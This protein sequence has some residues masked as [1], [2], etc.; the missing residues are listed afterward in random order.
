MENNRDLSNPIPDD[1]DTYANNESKG[2]CNK[3]KV[4]KILPVFFDHI[5]LL[6]Q[7]IFD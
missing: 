5:F 6:D 3:L 2:G 4:S 1:D 7:T